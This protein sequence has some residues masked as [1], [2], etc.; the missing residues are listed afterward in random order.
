MNCLNT[1]YK[2]IWICNDNK[3]YY[4][5]NIII[6]LYTY[7]WMIHFAREEYVSFGYE[8]C[9][10]GFAVKLYRN[11]SNQFRQLCESEFF[12]LFWPPKNGHSSFICYTMN[13]VGCC[14][15]DFQSC[16]LQIIHCLQIMC[17]YNMCCVPVH[18]WLRFT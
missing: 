14:Q 17:I 2:H 15:I 7:I 12:Y 9:S 18:A 8:Q 3:C 16:C 6:I 11:R 10:K 5:I 13:I 4:N 1:K